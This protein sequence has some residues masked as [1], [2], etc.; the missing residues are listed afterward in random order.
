MV[1][2]FYSYYPSLV[3]HGRFFLEYF[4]MSDGK[5]CYRGV[6]FF[7]RPA[8]TVSC[9]ATIKALNGGRAP[10]H[11]YIAWPVDV[12]GAAPFATRAAPKFAPRDCLK[13]NRS[14][15][16]NAQFLMDDKG[17]KRGGSAS[18]DYKSLE[19]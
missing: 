5:S 2:F 14:D 16:E 13:G 17:K 7:R 10:L 19:N 18:E 3:E 4:S 1:L 8:L 12:D 11:S 9:H 15:G 6:K